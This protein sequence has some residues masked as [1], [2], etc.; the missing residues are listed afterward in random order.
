[1][2]LLRPAA[3]QPALPFALS[4]ALLLACAPA[5]RAQTPQQQP[6]QRPAQDDDVERVT[7]E[8]VQTDV[9]VHD[10]EGRFVDNLT[11]EQFELRVD[12]KPQSIAFFERVVAGSPEE[13]AQLAA[14][15]RRG[16]TRQTAAAVNTSANL[17][18]DATT[19]TNTTATTAASPAAA[20]R[21]RTVYFFVDD[22]H[23]DAESFIRA[24][25]L[26]LQAVETQLGPEDRAAVVTAGGVSAPAV[27]TTDKAALKA[28]AQSMG[29]RQGLFR[30]F[31]RPPM[32]EL[33]ALSVSRNDQ[34]VIDYYADYLL[35][36][37]LE[38][39]RDSAVEAVK[40]R[41]QRILEASAPLAANTLAAL[42]Q[43]VRAAAQSPGRKLIF[44]VSDGFLVESDRANSFANLR[45]VTDAAAREGVLVYTLGARGVNSTTP[46]ADEPGTLRPSATNIIGDQAT[47]D[48]LITLAADTGGRAFVNANDMNSGVRRA[49]Q[50]T[51]VY[52]LLAWNPPRDARVAPRFRNIEVSIVGRPDL[53]ARTR[54]NL[55]AAV[56]TLLA[57]ASAPVSPNAGSPATSAAPVAPHE[58]LLSTLAGSATTPAQQ[59]LPASLVVV[60]RHAP[61]GG[62]GYVLT[63]SVQVA[64]EAVALA[65][66]AQASALDFAFLVLDA[67]GK[68]VAAFSRRAPVVAGASGA[69]HYQNFEFDA[70]AGRYTVRAAARDAATGRTASFAQA[71][72]IPDPAAGRLALSSLL[73]AEQ[74]DVTDSS[75]ESPR[76][77]AR[78][79]AQTSRL[80]FLAYA[81]NA[82]PDPANGNTPDLELKLVVTRQ[83]R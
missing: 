18:A 6:P 8:L 21:G 49:L 20:S 17:K 33:M 54:S 82:A 37:R 73:L 65:P 58:E 52:Y 48:V 38:L 23:L 26:V 27:L 83:G 72:E 46:G 13:P 45:R 70:P 39:S 74:R 61:A 7:S 15:N 51:A 60:Y 42:E 36:Q 43:V 44:F 57:S 35:A 4:L 63:S 2:N 32:S 59:A 19:P 68:R 77:V 31:E 81:Y 28:A 3:A 41:A 76:G 71:V 34:R 53:K 75:A 9:T 56:S 1:M 66:G 5:S 50:E 10:K 69:L 16:P 55:A 64:P 14:A 25:K 47:T 12:G 40:S 11:A 67:Q 62:R 22:F 24:R 78:R 80:R 29:R 79:F 30:D